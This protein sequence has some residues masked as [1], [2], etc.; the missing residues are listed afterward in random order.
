MGGSGPG[1]AQQLDRTYNAQSEAAN[2]PFGEKWE[3]AWTEHL[4]LYDSGEIVYAA[5]GGANIVFTPGLT[6]AIPA[7][8]PM[9]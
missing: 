2:G 4:R 5:P 6:A 1:S 8:K 3:S 7:A 9:I